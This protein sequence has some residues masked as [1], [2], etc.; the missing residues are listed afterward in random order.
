MSLHCVAWSLQSLYNTEGE[1][2]V[3]IRHTCCQL[4]QSVLKLIHITVC[5]PN[6]G[7]LVDYG[8]KLCY[9]MKKNTVV[10]PHCQEKSIFKFMFFILDI[11]I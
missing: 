11:N 2:C 7:P 5:F 1:L 9:A 10:S 8:R 6:G 4:N 3:A